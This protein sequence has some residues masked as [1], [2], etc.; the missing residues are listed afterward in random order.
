MTGGKM[1]MRKLKKKIV[2]QKNKSSEIYS[3]TQKFAT[4]HI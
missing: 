3:E 4:S 2:S 1:P